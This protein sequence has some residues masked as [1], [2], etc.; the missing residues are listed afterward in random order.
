MLFRSTQQYKDYYS[1]QLSIVHL[2]SG[3]VIG[4]DAF[5]TNFTDSYKPNFKPTNVYGRM[6]PIVNY[7]NTTRTI[8]VGVVVPAVDIEQAKEN[9][10]KLKLLGR[11]QYPSYGSIQ[12]ASGLATPPMCKVKF[13]NLINEADGHLYGYFAGFDFSPVVESGFFIDGISLFPKEY[14]ISLTYNV[15]HTISVGWRG[16]KFQ[17]GQQNAGTNQ[18]ETPS[19]IADG[20]GNPNNQANA[21]KLMG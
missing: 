14:K 6:D 18:G 17:Q 19:N 3:V 10:N 15:L 5:I 11:F 1:T 4:L 16:N 20:G 7:Q 8:T 21:N 9:F 2:P 12:G 13:G